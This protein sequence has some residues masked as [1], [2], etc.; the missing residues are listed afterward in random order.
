MTAI[1]NFV[2][3]GLETDKIQLIKMSQH[4]SD[5]Y[6]S[7]TKESSFI[8]EVKGETVFMRNLCEL[9]FPNIKPTQ[10]GSWTFGDFGEA[11]GPIQET[12]GTQNYNVK[13]IG[14][15]GMTQLG[16]LSPDGTK[17]TKIS[18][19]GEVDEGHVLSAQ[20]LQDKLDSREP[21]EAPKSMYKTQPENQGKIVWL[22]GPPGEPSII[23]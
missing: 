16:V 19:T 15:F 9:D 21:I 5:G 2:N 6:Y 13:M 11:P 7:F 23:F 1:K 12:T 22:S 4:W 18:F 20:E 3:E 8:Y 17:V 10:I 14:M